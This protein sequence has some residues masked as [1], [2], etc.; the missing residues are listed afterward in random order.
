MNEEPIEEL[1]EP[2]ISN[3]RTKKQICEDY[4]DYL[5]KKGVV[6]AS[7]REVFLKDRE[8]EILDALFE[9]LY[10][11]E[12]HQGVQISTLNSFWHF[13][14]FILCREPVRGLKI[15][16]KFVLNLFRDIERHRYSC[17]L[18]SRGMGKSYFVFVLYVL[19]KTFLFKNTDFL[20]VSNVP[21][22]YIRNMRELKRMILSNEMLL[23]KKKYDCIW[24]KDEIEY[25]GGLIQAQSVGTPPRGSHVQY[26]FVDDCLRDDNKISEEEL[27]NFIKGQLLPCAQRWKSRMALT[28]TPLH[29]TDV[30]HD[31]MNTKPE[32]KGVLIEDGNISHC[33]FYSKCY[34]IITDMEHKE[35]FLP[36]LFS[37]DELISNSNSI[38]NIQGD[39]IFN[40]EYLLNCT[41]KSTTI[42][43]Y[44]MLQSIQ[45]DSLFTLEKDDH[46]GNYI[47]GVDVA[48]SGEASA[49]FSAF[50]TLELI[51]TKDGFKKIVR[52]VEHV[53]GMAISGDKTK[54]GE[55]IDYGQVEEIEDIYHRF[56]DG[57]VVVEKNNVGI[58]HIQ[59]LR[60]RNVHVEEFMTDKFKKDNMI[61]YLVSEMKSGNLILPSD[62]IEI[63][64]LKQ[65]LLNFGIRKTRTG[66][67]KMQA[68][69]GHDDLCCL[70]GCFISMLNGFKKIEGV[71]IGD[72]VLT[73][74][75]NF[76][77]VK[78]VFIR[79]YVGDVYDLDYYGNE[80]FS[81][82]ENHPVYDIVLDDFIKVQDL[83]FS[84]RFLYPKC[85][86][87]VGKKYFDLSKYCSNHYIIKEDVIIHNR[88][89]KIKFKKVIYNDD[90][91][92]RFLGLFL[93]EGHVAQKRIQLSFHKKEVELIKFCENLIY[94]IFGL[95]CHRIIEDEKNS[96][97]LEIYS[98]PLSD[99]LRSFDKKELKKLPLEF[100]PLSDK[101]KN[102]LC[103]YYFLGDGCFHKNGLSS[104]SISY[105]ITFLIQSFLNDVGIVSS[106]GFT[107]KKN[108][109]FKK[110]YFVSKEQKSLSLFRE[111]LFLLRKLL[112]EEDTN[113]FNLYNV[114]IPISNNSSVMKSNFNGRSTY[115]KKVTK[116][117]YIGKVYNLEVEDDNSYVVNGV[118]VHNCMALGIAN[119]AAQ[120]RGGLA[121]AIT[122]N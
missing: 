60:K 19:F 114:A 24:T 54:D 4:L 26:I 68:L 95:K 64:A 67:E 72:V 22:Q 75:G 111:S 31:L 30:Y 57:L 6:E 45:D 10:E 42:F 115:L 88:G 21:R 109:L 91:F 35:I 59:E 8:A 16:N 2:E 90:D 120:S 12:I 84:N 104:S 116:R 56:N 55:I 92:S 78:N 61:R 37:W 63:K 94:K 9:Q 39:D 14:E 3:L 46:N 20:L 1:P 80:L 108:N 11:T 58:A 62:T 112:D 25:N 36:D 13:C 52:Y 27:D 102:L 49:D 44:D 5:I 50:I 87:F 77:K 101:Q 28:G 98:K 121:F 33:G 18:A 117:S 69:R 34:P 47:T 53:K 103:F 85:L 41:D 83:K 105:N 81:L 48:T 15:W 51:E 76:K 43:S 93:A 82:T 100:Y 66:K 79:D 86:E 118:S 17:L 70:P 107:N 89:R 74:K 99:F 29:I 97:T 65:E 7:E 106:Q 119:L 73:H 122:Q 110:D 96:V 40:R 113:L 23:Q 38:K 71:E 32:F